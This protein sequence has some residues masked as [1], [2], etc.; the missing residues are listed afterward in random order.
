MYPRRKG[1][2]LVA[3]PFAGV[4]VALSLVSMYASVMATGLGILAFGFAMTRPTGR[5]LAHSTCLFCS[6]K[7]IFEHEGDFCATCNEPIH[8]KC[9]D[10][11]KMAAH[12]RV[13]DQPFR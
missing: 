12:S 6:R 8:G 1:F 13:N 11:H 5:S 9:M 4:V 2:L 7:I 10:E 3:I